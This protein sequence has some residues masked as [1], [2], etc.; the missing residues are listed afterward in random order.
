[1]INNSVDQK[2]VELPVNLLYG[3]LLTKLICHLCKKSGNK[4]DF[5]FIYVV[6]ENQGR[7]EYAQKLTLLSKYSVAM[8]LL[9]P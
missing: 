4:L 9:M 6:G 5:F 7:V 2:N 3:C 8:F 1:M